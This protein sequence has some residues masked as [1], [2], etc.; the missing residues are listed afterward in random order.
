MNQRIFDGHNDV[1]LRLWRRDRTGER[2]FG[3]NAEG[4]VDLVRA[5][6]GGLAGGIFATFVMDEPGTGRTATQGSVDAPPVGLAQERALQVTLAQLAIAFRIERR[7]KGEVR[8]CRTSAEV[9][10][11]VD[12]GTFAM[13]LHM[14]GA[15]A[16]GPDLDELETLYAAGVR[17]LGLVWSRP[18]VFGYGVPFRFPS[19]PDIGEGL[20]ERGV[21]LV[22]ACNELGV[23][24]DCSHLNEKGFWDV[25]RVSRA[26]VVATHSN[27]HVLSPCSRNLTDAQM[28]AIR[29]SEGVA[30]LNFATSFLR[31]DGRRDPNTSL[32]T[33]RRHLDHMLEKLGPRGVALGSDFDGAFLPS[34][35][36][37]ATGLP[38][39]VAAMR[40]GG[41]SN[42]LIDAICYRNWLDVMIR[43]QSL[44]RGTAPAP[45]H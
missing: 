26:P 8:I 34:G 45:A 19:S 9:Q 7:S 14:E 4:H 28:D 42:D 39:L 12:A 6:Q 23:M 43:T 41:Y 20:T 13:M 24:V 33:M 15:E 11:A 5:R 31:D 2:F 36:G 35:I 37:D 21:A 38:R 25:V 17:S 40:A 3:S 18:T 27:A 1:L 16:I 32:D 29:D 44:G 22:T 10:A 30:G